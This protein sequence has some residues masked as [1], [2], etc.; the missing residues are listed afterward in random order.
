MKKV[1]CRK[2]NYKRHYNQSISGYDCVY[3][4]NFQERKFVFFPYLKFIETP[5]VEFRGREKSFVKRKFKLEEII[6]ANFR[7]RLQSIRKTSCCC[8]GLFGEVW[9]FYKV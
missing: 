5:G 3:Q 1:S 6:E 4:Q 7:F 8:Q 2:L 9:E